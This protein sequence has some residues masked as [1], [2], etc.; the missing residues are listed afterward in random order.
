MIGMRESTKYYT[1]GKSVCPSV[2]NATLRATE[3]KQSSNRLSSVLEYR[4]QR[5]SYEQDIGLRHSAANNA[6]E[7]VGRVCRSAISMAG[8]LLRSHTSP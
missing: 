5:R 2:T 1:K 8:F 3:L 4:D 7:L 6:A